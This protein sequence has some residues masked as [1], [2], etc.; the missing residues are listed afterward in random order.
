M[1][2]FPTVESQRESA[3]ALQERLFLARL[4]RNGC[5]LAMAQAFTARRLR[6]VHG[7]K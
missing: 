4:Q 2:T 1:R 7:L 3:R 5:S 6:E